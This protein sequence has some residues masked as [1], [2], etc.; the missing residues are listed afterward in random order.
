M[1]EHSLIPVT[2]YPQ[3]KTIAVSPGSSLFEA[4]IESGFFIRGF[5]G[6]RGIC[7]KCKVKLLNQQLPHTPVEMKVLSEEERKNGI[8]LACKTIVNNALSVEVPEFGGDKETRALTSDSNLEFE[9]DANIQKKQLSLQESSLSDQHADQDLLLQAL[10]LPEPTE[11]PLPVMQKL[12]QTLR[13]S[14]YDITAVL[15]GNRVISIEVGHNLDKFGVAF[16]V[17]TTTIVGSLM[18]LNSGK[19]LAVA[20]RTNPQ[21]IHGADVISRINYCSSHVDGLKKLQ[22]LA[23]AALN[24]IIEEVLEQVDSAPENV[25]E[26]SIAGNATMNH[27]IMGIDPSAIAAMPFIPAFKRSQTVTAGELALKAQPLAPVQILANISGYVGGDIVALILAYDIHHSDKLTLALDIGTNGEI[28]LGSRKRLLSCSAAAGP[29]FEGGHISSGMRAGIGAIDKIRLN[30][31]DL[32]IHV[33]G[34]V[35]PV[36]LCGTGLI[37][38]AA[39]LCDTRIIDSTGQITTP[40]GKIPDALQRRI[41]SSDSGNDFLLVPR[42]ETQTNMPIIISQRDVRELQLAKGAIAAG[43]EVLF[44]EL[45][46]GAADVEQVLIAGAFGNYI[47]KDNT[48]KIGLL[49]DIDQKLVKFVGNAAS[50]GAK[51]FLL[52]NAARKEAQRIIEFTEYVE[53]SARPDFQDKFMDAMMF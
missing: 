38:A 29:A 50:M 14:G 31:N 12:P 1:T 37:D 7:G 17:G 5:C 3:N 40:D 53:L 24:E 44:N 45:G 46:I 23:I 6:G 22:K 35:A 26:I 2:F 4:A 15:A 48:F 49:P 36:G 52:S 28:V 16:D 27:L 25:Y 10:A 33:I 8:H 18:D 11:I 32:H 21:A 9:L 43:V 42:S 51:K 41:I 30:H 39:V 19:M 13:S 20:A 47:D 34:D